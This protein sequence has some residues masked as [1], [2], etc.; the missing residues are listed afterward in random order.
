MDPN[1][2]KP[3]D[4]EEQPTSSFDS[5]TPTTSFNSAQTEDVVS[6]QP[7]VETEPETAPVSTAS[8]AAPTEAALP[9]PAPVAAIP[10]V[11]DPGH[12]LGIASL[13]VSLLGAGLVGLI[14][15][16]I[17]LKKSKSAGH[18]NGLALAGI[19]IGAVNMI[20]G[21]IIGTILLLGVMALV[22][23]CGDLGAGSHT[24]SDG[25]V[26]TCN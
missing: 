3:T 5:T 18:G 13:V 2:E 6:P 10:A 7:A 26:I 9:A 23:Q 22:A 11:T 20:V 21:L 24:L 19:I 14:L 12:G 15:G 25:T 4:N 17:G 1:Q 16:I 8:F